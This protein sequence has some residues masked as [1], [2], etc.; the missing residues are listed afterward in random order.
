MF[1][2]VDLIDGMFAG[3]E[4]GMLVGLSSVFGYLVKVQI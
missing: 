2:F 1:L 4:L 3:M